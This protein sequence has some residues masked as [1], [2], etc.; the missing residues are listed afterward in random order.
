VQRGQRLL[1]FDIK[2]GYRHFRLHDAMRPFFLFHYAGRVYASVALPFG[3]WRSPYWFTRLLKPMVGW[4]RRNGFRVLAYL[5]DFLL[6]LRTASAATAQDCRA[7]SEV[8]QDLLYALGI[9]RHPIKGTWG[10]EPRSWSIWA[11]YLTPRR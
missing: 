4:L 1:A 9:T 6:G 5:D 8:I 11:F 2:S 10:T 7:A 3:W